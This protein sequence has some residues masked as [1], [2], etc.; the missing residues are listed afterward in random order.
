MLEHSHAKAIPNAL[1]I[2][3]FSLSLRKNIM[4][5]NKVKKLTKLTAMLLILAALASCDLCTLFGLDYDKGNEDQTPQQPTVEEAKDPGYFYTS[6]NTEDYL[7]IDAVELIPEENKLTAVDKEGEEE[8]IDLT[9][10]KYKLGRAI[11]TVTLEP[12]ERITLSCSDKDP[13]IYTYEE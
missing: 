9:D 10:N 8:T 1:T 3:V 7:F 6:G 11:I 13:L 4:E 5:D 2:P 12:K